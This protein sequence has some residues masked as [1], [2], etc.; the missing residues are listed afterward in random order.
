MNK[1]PVDHIERPS[2]PW[3]KH[4]E[5]LTECGILAIKIRTLTRNDFQRRLKEW[6]DHRTAITT[7]MTCVD[8]ARRWTD[9]ETDPRQALEREINWEGC[10]RWQRNSRGTRLRDEL[11]AI[12]V[13]IQSHKEEFVEVFH[14]IQNTVDFLAERRKRS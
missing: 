6:G 10:G 5:C 13:L 11:K 4:E 9:W 12:A 14:R 8:A 7:C 1:E 3:R 2:L